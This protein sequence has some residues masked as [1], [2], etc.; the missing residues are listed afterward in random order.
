MSFSLAQAFTPGLQKRSSAKNSRHPIRK[1]VDSMNRTFAIL[2]VAAL[3]CLLIAGSALAQVFAQP[4]PATPP[5]AGAPPAAAAPL[6]TP[7]VAPS[8]TPATP[9]PP[10]HAPAPVPVPPQAGGFIRAVGPGGGGGIVYQAG[11]GWG[12]EMGGFGLGPGQDDPELSKLIQTEHELV[13]Q[14]DDLVRQYSATED[15]G[16]REKLRTQ[17]RELLGKQFV[18]QQQR[19][20]REL[21]RVEERLSKLREQLKKRSSARDTI[22]DRRLETLT[23]DADGLGW[24]PPAGGGP[25]GL[26]GGIFGGQPRQPRPAVAR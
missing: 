25:Q 16:Q 7:A 9:R 5:A 12:G 17:L 20:E 14:S 10:A 23:S 6:D 8:A 24:T 11:P 19:R 3:G 1:D 26:G 22:I 13:R 18:A 2:I 21:V 15:Y 4:A